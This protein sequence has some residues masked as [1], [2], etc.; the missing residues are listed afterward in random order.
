[1]SKRSRSDSTEARCGCVQGGGVK[2]NWS[3]SIIETT[4]T[5]RRRHLIVKYTP[6]Q[7]VSEFLCKRNSSRLSFSDT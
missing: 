4:A 6:C 2:E 3:V 7:R 1:M 5:S